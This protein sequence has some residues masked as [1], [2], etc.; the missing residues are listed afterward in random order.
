MFRIHVREEHP[1][2][3]PLGSAHVPQ[4]S[5]AAREAKPYAA[6]LQTPPSPAQQ[7]GAPDLLFQQRENQELLHHVSRASS[8]F[9]LLERVGWGFERRGGQSL[10]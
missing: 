8:D 6:T 10:S 4:Q 3:V 2:R 9:A 7:G 1:Q 5:A